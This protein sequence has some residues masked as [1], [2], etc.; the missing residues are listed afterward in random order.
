MGLFD[1]IISGVENKVSNLFTPPTL[2]P[3]GTFSG[4][5]I[6][7]YP[8]GDVHNPFTPSPIF[9]NDN[10]SPVS[11]WVTTP[12]ISPPVSQPVPIINKIISPISTNPFQ[13][14]PQNRQT[15]NNVAGAIGDIA[16]GVGAAAGTIA[17]GGTLLPAIGVGLGVSAVAPIIAGILSKPKAIEE[18]KKYP[19]SALNLGQN[20]EQLAENPSVAGIEK[21]FKENPILA[22]AITAGLGVAGVKTATSVANIISTERNTSAL[23]KLEGSGSINNTPP[24]GQNTNPPPTINIINQL[25]QAPSSPTKTSKTLTSK[26]PHRRTRRKTIKRGKHR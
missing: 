21:V 11:S 20:I 12:I 14:S 25:P 8:I 4:P 13:L 10:A 24:T 3:L 23:E 19:S 9:N 16:L 26:K 17:T 6:S 2:Y 18:L 1:S 15:F 5:K 22:S 7:L